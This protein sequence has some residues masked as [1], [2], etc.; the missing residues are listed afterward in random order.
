MGM[1]S[2]VVEVMDNYCG[3]DCES[4]Q[5]QLVGKKSKK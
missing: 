1:W 5:P 3:A 2:L 4:A